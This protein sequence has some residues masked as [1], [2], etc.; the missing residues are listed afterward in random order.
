HP[1]LQHPRQCLPPAGNRDRV[2]LRVAGHVLA[3]AAFSLCSATFGQSPTTINLGTQGRNA[4]FSTLPITRPVSVGTALPATCLVGQLFFMSS[5]VPGQ[6]L[7]A[8][9]S[10]N[11]WTQ[12][13]GGGGAAPQVSLSKPSVSFGNQTINTKSASQ[14]ITLSDPGYSFLG[15]TSI[16]VTGPNATDF[17]ASNNCASTVPSGA[18]CTITVS[19]TPSIVSA[20]SAAIS[21][22]DS[23][24]G[25]PHTIPLTGTGQNL[26]T[27]GGLSI[28]PTATSAQIGG[29][30]SISSNRPVNWSLAAGSV[31]TLTVADTTHATYTAPASIPN[32][33]VMAGRPVLPNDSVFNTR[34]DN[35]PV[36]ANNANWT[37]TANTGTNGLGFD[38]GWGTSVV[39]NT[40]PLTNEIFYYTGGYNG[41]WLLPFLP[42]LKREMGTYVSDQNG[43]DH[44]I[45]AV[46]KDT[47]QF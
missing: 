7:Y 26:I 8:C 38:T 2:T 35:L 6:N 47:C 9:T 43:S 36:N 33:N 14:T 32:Q 5:A 42:E 19:F 13:A 16:T 39:D 41:S 22:V 34:I 10:V 17:A 15:I 25:S 29:T 23:A 12:L 45:L 37:S 28:N 31:G 40:V 24:P 20:E 21:I 44:H 27:S 18:S 4:D 3:V 30:V 1:L 11:N 46:N